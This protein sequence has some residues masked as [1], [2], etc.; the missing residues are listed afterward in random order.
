MIPNISVNPLV[1]STNDSCHLIIQLLPSK[2][3]CKSRKRLPPI[4]PVSTISFA[5]F[6]I[7]SDTLVNPWG[8]NA[9]N[10]CHLIPFLSHT[11]ETTAQKSI[12]QEQ[13]E[14]DV[15]YVETQE[16][17]YSDLTYLPLDVEVKDE[18]RRLERCAENTALTPIGTP[19]TAYSDSEYEWRRWYLY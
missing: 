15:T 16:K 18:F 14:T 4:S 19:T 8:A 7:I 11:D 5:W 12:L 10:S 1:A 2:V 3:F 9:N 13:E 17:V 6:C